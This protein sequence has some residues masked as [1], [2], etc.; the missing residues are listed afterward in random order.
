M[1]I[2]RESC[3]AG[4]VTSPMRH[5]LPHWLPLQGAHGPPQSRPVS[6]GSSTPLAHVGRRHAPPAHTSPLLQARSSVQL[7]P[8]ATRHARFQ[9]QSTSSPQSTN[10]SLSLST[11]SVQETSVAAFVMNPVQFGRQPDAR[12]GS[13]TSGAVRN[14]SPQKAQC[15]APVTPAL[16]SATSKQSTR[17]SPSLSTPSLHETSVAAFVRN[18]EQSVLHPLCSAISQTS[19]VPTTP[20][21]H[22]QPPAGHI[23]N[24]ALWSP[25]RTSVA[26]ALKSLNCQPSFQ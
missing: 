26:R 5:A 9:P 19:P 13:Q 7:T 2:S 8:S 24:L 22:G 18:P 25:R 11:P 3:A 12:P 15:E 23:R 17:A 4:A 1:P 6:P 21:P 20:S 16:Q 10:A 14:P